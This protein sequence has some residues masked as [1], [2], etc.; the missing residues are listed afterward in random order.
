MSLTPAQ[1][2]VSSTHHASTVLHG[3]GLW[4]AR[5]AWIS[6]VTLIVVLFVA[7]LPLA[8]QQASSPGQVTGEAL[9]RF[10][11]PVP[12]AGIVRVMVDGL[13][14]LG[15]LGI[16]L[17]I[18]W[19]R[20]NDWMALF[21]SAMLM[22]TALLFTAPLRGE[23]RA[24]LALLYSLAQVSQLACLLLFPS[25]SFVPRWSW[26][27]LVPVAGW[28]WY[29]WY[30]LYLPNALVEDRIALNITY[31]PESSR[32]T[33]L[34]VGVFA[35]GMLAQVYRYRRVSTPIERQQMKWLLWSVV[36]ALIVGGGYVIILNIL[37]SL[38]QGDTYAYLWRIVGRTV[39]QVAFLLIPVSLVYAIL[40]FRLWDID[41]I[42]NRALVYGV[43]T[44]VLGSV[45]VLSIVASQIVL[46][47]FIGR[48]FQGAVAISTLAIAALFNPVRR[49]VQDAID[50]QF[51]RHKYDAQQTVAAFGAR[52]REHR[53]LETL[54]H[55]LVQAVQG[56]MQ[57]THVSLWLCEP[58]H[59]S[60]TPPAGNKRT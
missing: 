28:R 21:M 47:P 7:T 2:N 27:L 9:G 49:R 60:V 59:E 36:V 56:T 44:A 4:L 51:Y 16:S 37:G 20:S 52:L 53:D 35:I 38:P 24:L 50:R 40:R 57:P 46:T 22:L 5:A 18:F 43:L 29:V 12:V 31:V 41:M 48:D 23:P 3:Y 55:D 30:S 11:A 14:M 58:T 17:L 39:R 34:L 26:L 32:D 42:V 10:V 1:A 19:R 15:F 33:A 6:L 25:G 13:M 45:Y 8:Y 54:T